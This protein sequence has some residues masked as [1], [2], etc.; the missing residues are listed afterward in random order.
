MKYYEY[1]SVHESL[2]RRDTEDPGYSSRN[3]LVSVQALEVHFRTSLVEHS[4][5]HSNTTIYRTVLVLLQ[6][7]RNN[8]TAHY[9]RYDS[10]S[11]RIRARQPTD[12]VLLRYHTSGA[13]YLYSTGLY[14][15]P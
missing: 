5:M 7:V 12:I 14:T 1:F 3:L 8:G 10:V 13:R 2:W 11:V 9:G 4:L 6:H 15:Y